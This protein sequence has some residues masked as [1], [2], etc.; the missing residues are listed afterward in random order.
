MIQQKKNLQ[1]A[2]IE[3]FH[4]SIRWPDTIAFTVNLLRSVVIFKYTSTIREISYLNASFLHYLC[5]AKK[6]QLKKYKQV[7]YFFSSK[8]G[9]TISFHLFLFCSIIQIFPFYRFIKMLL[10]W[11]HWSW[12]RYAVWNR[13]LLYVLKYSLN[14]IFK[15]DLNS[16]IC[17]YAQ[18][19]ENLTLHRIKE[20]VNFTRIN[21]EQIILPIYLNNHSKQ[22]IINHVIGNISFVFTL[23]KELS[24]IF[25]KKND[26]QNRIKK[27]YHR[28]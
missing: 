3:C 1:S 2:F 28:I 26:S 5:R 18:A 25:I 24:H 10:N 21:W 27:N 13:D 7:K 11:S 8:I 17:V 20:F 19:K 9:F 22:Y 16:T 6:Q 14:N 23:H 12:M 4:T 15:L